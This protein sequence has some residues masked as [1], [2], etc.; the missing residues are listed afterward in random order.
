MIRRVCCTGALIVGL[1]AT[2]G[3]TAS[4]ADVPPATWVPSVCTSLQQYQQK[5]TNG[6]D[7]LTTSLTSIKNLKQ[8]RATI[9]KFLA[10]AVTAAKTAKQQVEAAGSP[11]VT[12]GQKIATGLVKALDDSVK[13]FATSKAK[14]EKV[15]IKNQAAFQKQGTKVGTDLQKAAAGLQNGVLATLT[16]D[17]SGQISAAATAAPECA[18]I[19]SS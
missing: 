7:A 15:S 18:F 4:A 10:S 6:S 12:N 19:T 1:L 5:V 2:F 14:A 17:T 3:S 13:L 8:G 11:S 16:L 9:V